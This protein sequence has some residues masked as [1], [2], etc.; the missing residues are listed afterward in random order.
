MAGSVVKTEEF[1]IFPSLMDPFGIMS[2]FTETRNWTVVRRNEELFPLSGLFLLNRLI[3]LFIS[4]GLLLMSYHFT[5][6]RVRN[7]SK[8]KKS[9]KR[10]NRNK[11]GFVQTCCRETCR[12]IVSSPGVCCTAP[13]GNRR[14]VPPSSLP[15]PAASLDLSLCHRSERGSTGRPLWY[16]LLC[17]YRFYSGKTAFHQ[18]C[19]FP[20]RVLWCRDIAPERTVRMEGLVF[21]SPAPGW[22]L[23]SA[24]ATTLL[25][26]V[27]VLVT[28]NIATGIAIQLYTGAAPSLAEY[29]VLYYLSAWPMFLFAL[30]ILFIQAMIKNKFLGM[31][32]SLVI[33]GVF[34]FR[35]HDRHSPSVV[36][37]RYPARPPVFSTQWFWSSYGSGELVYVL[38][39]LACYTA[40]LDSRQPLATDH[41]GNG[42]S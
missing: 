27:I 11:T 41:C 7:F 14:P 31:M 9:R 2:F 29:L 26:L 3:W 1:S 23:W 24:K 28:A 39:D 18:P 16:P 15:V 36:T 22:I 33:C 20:A 13:A 34:V 19:A 8:K 10:E 21:S 30:L 37:L 6:F 12:S 5:R 38:L 35:E 42:E 40:C 25:L 32:L 17:G 4:F